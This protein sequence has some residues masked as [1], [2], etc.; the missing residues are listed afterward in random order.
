LR[1][2]EKEILE[3]KDWKGEAERYRLV[4]IGPG[5][6]AFS[7]KPGM[8]HN[9]P[10]HYLCAN[11]DNRK[12]KSLLQITSQGEYGRIYECHNCKSELQIV[13]G[14]PKVISNL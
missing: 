7:L 14:D 9:E 8:E 12:Q 1:D 2:L 5:L 13:T 11:G 3:L 6:F 10:R 4:E